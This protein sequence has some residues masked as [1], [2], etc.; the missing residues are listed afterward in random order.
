MNQLY[1]DRGTLAVGFHG[2]R[3]E[4]AEALVKNPDDIRISRNRW[5]WLGAGFYIWENN[6]ERAE[7]WAR[8]TYGEDGA[9]VGVVYELG[10]CLDLMD[11]SSIK[12]V[13]QARDVFVSEV[14]GHGGEIPVNKDLKSDVNSDK[15]L[16]MF[17]CAVINFLTSRMDHAFV[18]EM[19]SKGFSKSHA[20]DSVRGCFNE[21]GKIEG[22]EIYEKTHI[23]IAL[24]NMNCI[25]GVFLPRQE[26]AFPADLND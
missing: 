16:R 25:K 4:V 26:K 10:T 12:M 23:Q 2:C 9:V 15:L 24:R 18:L 3:R 6:L 8:N 20:F 11:S 13:K 17:D 5:D 14:I 21:G 22:M 7:E 19:K 1:D